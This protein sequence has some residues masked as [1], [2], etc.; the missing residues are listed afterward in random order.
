MNPLMTLYIIIVGYLVSSVA[1]IQTIG[2]VNSTDN[3]QVVVG[4]VMLALGLMVIIFVSEL[5][6]S[7]LV[8]LIKN[9]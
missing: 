6:V 3:I 8:D 9:H 4:T 7:K 1:I 5:W 2:M